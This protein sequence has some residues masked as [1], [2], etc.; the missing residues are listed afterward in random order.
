MLSL[1]KEF[2]EFL[3]EEKKLWL[4][5]IVVIL[6]IAG[7]NVVSVLLPSQLSAS[8]VNR[9]KSGKPLIPW[10]IG[11][12]LV[13]VGSVFVISVGDAM[14]NAALEIWFPLVLLFVAL[15]GI[16]V[17]A[18]TLSWLGSLFWERR[19]EILREILLED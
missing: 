7:G 12:V 3:W 6:L 15:A 2:C 13:I 5:P 8:L 19:N 16:G 1:I 4:L 18:L 14:E 9:S 10:F 17:Y 11:T